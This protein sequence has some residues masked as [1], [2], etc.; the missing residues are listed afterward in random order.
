MLWWRKW[1]DPALGVKGY[2]YRVGTVS[3]V[4]T[5]T[6]G[7]LPTVLRCVG[8]TESNVPVPYWTYRTFAIKY[9]KG[10]KMA[11]NNFLPVSFLVMRCSNNLQTSNVA[12]VVH[13]YVWKNELR[14]NT[15]PT[16]RYHCKAT[17][18]QVVGSCCVTILSNIVGSCAGTRT[19]TCNLNVVPVPTYRN[20]G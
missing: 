3:T 19:G 5:G 7:Y 8:R 13:W 10:K 17:V 2:N 12:S 14:Y 4:G 20:V 9:K 11:L 6:S 15:A 1:P 16:Y 18:P